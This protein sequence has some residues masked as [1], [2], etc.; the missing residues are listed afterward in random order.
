MASPQR[1]LPLP[2]IHGAAISSISFQ[3]LVVQ[4]ASSAGKENLQ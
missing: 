2:V 3:I 4:T 1:W